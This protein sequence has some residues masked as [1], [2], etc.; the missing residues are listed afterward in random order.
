MNKNRYALIAHAHSIGYVRERI[1]VLRDE[2]RKEAEN[3][4]AYSRLS[5]AINHLIVA[6]DTLREI[7]ASPDHNAEPAFR[8]VRSD[9]E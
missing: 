2:A 4:A 9:N 6:E 7:A 3:S 8:S 5:I 1:T